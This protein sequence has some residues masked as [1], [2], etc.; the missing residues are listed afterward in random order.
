MNNRQDRELEV[1]C[2]SMLSALNA[3]EGGAGRIELCSALALDGLTPS[4]GLTRE[5][6]LLYPALRIHVL[7]RPRE[8]NFVYSDA[9]LCAMLHDIELAAAAG[10]TAIVAGALT[11][12]G[13]IDIN[14]T[15][16]L[17]EAAGPLPFTFH[18]AFDA[19]NDQHEALEQLAELGAARVLTSG[20]AP[21]ALHGKE[22][23]RKLN[24]QAAGRISILPGGG[25][26]SNN[27]RLI[28][29]HT[30]AREIHGSCATTLPSGLRVTS[31]DEVKH[32]LTTINA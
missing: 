13:D 21:T 32:I 26:N 22:Q 10:A 17:I 8:G 3:V 6:R 18:R 5:L 29:D 11:P 15:R 9:E 23:L 20:G 30:G 14:A 12:A 25:V 19:V 31:A 27:A 1:C 16:R 2:G 7:I 28:L 4:I 24:Q